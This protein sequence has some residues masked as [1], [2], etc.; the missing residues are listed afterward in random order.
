MPRRRRRYFVDIPEARQFLDSAY[1][2]RTKEVNFYHL[3]IW[4]PEF[5]GVFDWYHTQGTVVVQ[6]KDFTS[7]IGEAGTDEDVALLINNYVIS[8]Q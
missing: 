6:T 5:Q 3:K 1:G 4:H 8:K 2:L 7:N